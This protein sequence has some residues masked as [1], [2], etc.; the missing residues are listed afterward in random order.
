MRTCYMYPTI[1]Y[2][3]QICTIV[4]MYCSHYPAFCPKS[5]FHSILYLWRAHK[6]FAP[7]S[8]AQ[9]RRQPQI[10][11]HMTIML[12]DGAILFL[13]TISW[14]CNCARDNAL[15]LLCVYVKRRVEHVVDSSAGCIMLG[16]GGNKK[17]KLLTCWLIILLHKRIT[18]SPSVDAVMIANTSDL[19]WYM[20]CSSIVVSFG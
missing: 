18:C 9:A 8:H 16:L 19:L 15:L 17:S 13:F 20:Y 1:W 11:S 3:P 14:F 2:T 7:R 4:Y 6:S 12:D 10:H 5:L